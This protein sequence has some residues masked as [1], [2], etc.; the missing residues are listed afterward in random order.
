MSRLTR[1]LI[2]LSIALRIPTEHSFAC[3]PLAQPLASKHDGFFLTA[4]P[5]LR[6]KSSLAVFMLETFKLSRQH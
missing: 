5:R 3:T 2:I 1:T 6:G 4:R